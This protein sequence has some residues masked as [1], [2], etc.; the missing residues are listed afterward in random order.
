LPKYWPRRPGDSALYQIVE[1]H[2]ETF[3]AHTAGDAESSGL[4]VFVKREFEVYLRCG[5]LAHGFT[6][7]R[8]E[9][10]AFERLV[11]FSCKRREF[12]PSKRVPVVAGG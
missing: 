10:S 12:C 5:I 3:L 8:C 6:R 4:P 1:T 7:V 2:L 9:G 11:P